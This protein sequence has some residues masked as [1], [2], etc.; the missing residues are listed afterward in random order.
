MGRT[1][2]KKKNRSSVP[3][4]TQKPKSKKL[5]LTANPVVAANWKK[6]E[7]LSQN[8][9]RLGLV[10]RLN[11]RSGGVEKRALSSTDGADNDSL[12]IANKNLTTL[13]PGTAR[14]ERDPKTGAIVRVVEDDGGDAR[15]RRRGTRERE[16]KGRVLRDV[17]DDGASEEEEDGDVGRRV[18]LQ[19]DLPLTVGAGQIGEGV[20]VIPELMA[21][22]AAGGVRKRPR[23]QSKREEEWVERLVERY[24]DDVGR[25]AR[26]RRLNPMQ[27][28]EGDIARRVRLWRRK[29]D[30]DGEDEER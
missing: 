3:K 18:G 20:G 15:G 27:Q 29:Q 5:N 10:S 9:R 16:W 8:Y 19:H 23:K 17:L 1:L 24:G 7:T 11:S 13:V 4:A 21:Q 14:I 2:Q 26:D 12:A 30:D 28:S 6:N 22:A 25:M